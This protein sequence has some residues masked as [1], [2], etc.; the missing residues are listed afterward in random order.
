MHIQEKAYLTIQ[1]KWEVLGLG[2]I[3]VAPV[4]GEN[5]GLSTAP[6]VFIILINQTET[7]RG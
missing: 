6:S 7:G 3:S 5:C 4:L 1:P 2:S